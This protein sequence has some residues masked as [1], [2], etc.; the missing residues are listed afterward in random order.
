MGRDRRGVE[1]RRRR[2]EMGRLCSVIDN[3]DSTLQDAGFS[4]ELARLFLCDRDT[5]M[6]KKHM[7]A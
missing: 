1:M 5:S 4:A 6:H 2:F 3:E 7:A